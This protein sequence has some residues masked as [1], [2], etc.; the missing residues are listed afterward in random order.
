MNIAQ[1]G[2]SKDDARLDNSARRLLRLAILVFLFGPI[3]G[4]L[5]LAN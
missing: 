3:T 1:R 4:F 2:D 5:I